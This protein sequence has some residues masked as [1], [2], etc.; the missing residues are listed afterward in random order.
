VITLRHSIERFHT[1]WLKQLTTALVKVGDLVY[2]LHRI[3]I[4]LQVVGD[5]NLV[6]W[7]N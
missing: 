2:V 5:Y 4:V 1:R 7:S 3:G 6:L